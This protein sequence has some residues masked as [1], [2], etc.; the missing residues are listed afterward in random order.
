MSYIKLLLSPCLQYAYLSFGV[1]FIIHKYYVVIIKLFKT[2]N[3]NK[4]K[5]QPR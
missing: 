4:C 5:N 1:N 3:L 2:V